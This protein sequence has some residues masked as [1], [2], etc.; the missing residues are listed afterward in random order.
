M[1]ARRV[2]SLGR[3]AGR[4]VNEGFGR[5]FLG[6]GWLCGNRVASGGYVLK[7]LF[8]FM[9]IIDLMWWLRK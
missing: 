6:C 1:V 4:R 9:A 7:E 5:H 3:V 8:I 2:R